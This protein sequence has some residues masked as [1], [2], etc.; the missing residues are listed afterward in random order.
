VKARVANGVGRGKVRSEQKE[1][2][3]LPGV[4]AKYYD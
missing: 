4:K 1:E 3:I 2:E